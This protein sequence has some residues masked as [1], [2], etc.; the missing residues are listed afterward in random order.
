[1]SGALGRWDIGMALIW[2]GL[3]VVR[4]PADLPAPVAGVI[5]LPA[6]TAWMIAGHVDLQ[7]ARIVC[8]G[9][10]T[11]F[12]SGAETASITSTGLTGAPLVETGD[13]IQFRT[14]SL[15]APAGEVCVSVTGDGVTTAL[16]WTLVNFTGAGRALEAS[17]INNFVGETMGLLNG[18]G[19][20]FTGTANSVV[21]TDSIFAPSTGAALDVTGCLVQRR[22]RLTDCALVIGAG[23]TG[24]AVDDADIA[25]TEGMIV[26]FC[27]LS[28]AGTYIAPMTY[29]SDKAR[30][31]ECRGIQNTTRIGEL[32]LVTPAATTNPGVGV[33]AK[34]AGT[35]T[36][37]PINQRFD[38]SN[39]RLTY[40]SQLAIN[41]LVSATLT[42]TAGNGDQITV[43]A[44][45]NG[46][47]IP[48]SRVTVTANA[49][50]RVENLALQT[51]TSLAQND[52]VELWVANSAA[53]NVTATTLN[54]IVRQV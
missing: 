14:I 4:T 30:W 49:A 19:Y 24:V 26:N 31:L 10:T 37:D 3:H 51:S 54:L 46:V 15:A 47:E 5:T 33:F 29:L 50:G 38:H 52:F 22:V 32:Y 41:A 45:K 53:G 12:G 39:N 7:G 48:G 21:F 27:N 9:P 40:V 13:T 42:L 35:T 43:A 36:P 34:I 18:D 17:N 1:M 25:L 8:A 2:G 6:A 20:Y 11:I 28:G 16:D 44:Y 23:R